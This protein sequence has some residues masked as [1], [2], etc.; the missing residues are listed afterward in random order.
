LSEGLLTG[1]PPLIGV[2][3]ESASERTWLSGDDN[4]NRLH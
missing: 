2:V 4:D 3:P 1:V